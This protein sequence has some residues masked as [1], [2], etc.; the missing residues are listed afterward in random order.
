MKRNE[1]KD[2]ELE[3][4]HNIRFAQVGDACDTFRQAYS[5]GHSVLQTHISSIIFRGKHMVGSIMFY[6]HNF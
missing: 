2:K 1:H 6:K 3:F 5:W 4:Q